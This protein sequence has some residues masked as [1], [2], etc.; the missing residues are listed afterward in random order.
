M[1]TSSG[2]MTPV[3]GVELGGTKIRVARG[4]PDGCIGDSETFPTVG[5]EE[6]VQRIRAFFESGSAPAAIG[7]GAFGPITIDP[8]SP[9]YGRL[10]ATPKLGWLGFD[11]V[12]AIRA[13]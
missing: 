1:G 9:G 11:L 12:A 7:I 10:G 5:P 2:F 8:R 6:S 13:I 3:G 4:T